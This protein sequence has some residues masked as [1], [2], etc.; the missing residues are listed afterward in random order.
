MHNHF[1]TI[2]EIAKPEMEIQKAWEIIMPEIAKRIGK[3]RY[4]KWLAF[5]TEQMG[6]TTTE[7]QVETLIAFLIDN[8]D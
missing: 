5:T 1:K 3:K 4:E 6:E 7:A 8:I 2:L